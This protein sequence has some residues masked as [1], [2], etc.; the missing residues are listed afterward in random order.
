MADGRKVGTG[1]GDGEGGFLVG[2]GAEGHVGSVGGSV[3]GI[4]VGSG[5]GGHV[6]GVLVDEDVGSGVG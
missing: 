3:G 2:E 1:I 6:G 5:V 4:L